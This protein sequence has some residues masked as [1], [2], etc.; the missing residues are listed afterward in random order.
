MFCS[1][2]VFGLPLI[3]CDHVMW[4]FP[5]YKNKLDTEIGIEEWKLSGKV[6]LVGRQSPPGEVAGGLPSCPTWSSKVEGG[7]TFLGISHPGMNA[8]GCQNEHWEP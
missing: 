4:V 7:L 1:W 3:A 6:V 2:K 8:T 5:I